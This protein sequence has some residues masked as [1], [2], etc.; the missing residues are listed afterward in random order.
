MK[1]SSPISDLRESNQAGQVHVLITVKGD[2]RGEIVPKKEL[3]SVS[4]V[5]KMVT[6]QMFVVIQIY[7][8][9]TK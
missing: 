5:K 1:D 6:E 9:I 2:I 4:D 8:I 7:L 3:L